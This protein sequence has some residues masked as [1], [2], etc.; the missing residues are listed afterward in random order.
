VRADAGP[1]P[2]GLA[3]AAAVRGQAWVPAPDAALAWVPAG[4]ER[5]VPE[6]AVP[7]AAAVRAAGVVVAVWG[8]ARAAWGPAVSVWV[9][10]ALRPSAARG[11]AVPGAAV[12]RS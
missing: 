4:A 7:A 8:A 9:R 3:L 6:Q 12:G 2:A 11:A 10:A 1:G 5:A